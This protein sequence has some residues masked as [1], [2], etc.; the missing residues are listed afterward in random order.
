MGRPPDGGNENA[1]PDQRDSDPRNVP[2]APGRDWNR[3]LGRIVRHVL[4]PGIARWWLTSQIHAYLYV[5]L[6]PTFELANAAQTAFFPELVRLGRNAKLLETLF[7]TYFEFGHM[8]NRLRRTSQITT[9]PGTLM[10]HKVFV[11][12]VRGAAVLA[13]SLI[14]TIQRTHTLVVKELTRLKAPTIPGRIEDDE[15]IRLYDEWQQYDL[16]K[17]AADGAGIDLR[18]RPRPKDDVSA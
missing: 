10:H 5:Y 8:N 11:D 12:E 17:R 18:A 6:I 16:V 3:A 7:G 4:H 1:K 14:P 9:M 15:L 13:R 2:L